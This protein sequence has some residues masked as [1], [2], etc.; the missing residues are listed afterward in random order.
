MIIT[1]LVFYGLLVITFVVLMFW[2]DDIEKALNI[3][4]RGKFYEQ[5]RFLMLAEASIGGIFLLIWIF[6]TFIL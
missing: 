4:N 1:S 2:V 5:C 3:T 6:Q